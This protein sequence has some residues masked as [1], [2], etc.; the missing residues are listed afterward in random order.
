[1][2]NDIM[3][4]SQMGRI[5]DNS[6][7]KM[8]PLVIFNTL[9][10]GLYEYYEKLRLFEPVKVIDEENISDRI[11]RQFKAIYVG[12]EVE[13]YLLAGGFD[14]SLASTS[15]KAFLLEKGG[16]LREVLEMFV[17]R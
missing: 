1:M 6:Y 15:S 8:H 14:I 2:K 4:V 7:S 11:P 3:A 13:T 10:F 12:N 9:K 17:P 5:M 16:Y